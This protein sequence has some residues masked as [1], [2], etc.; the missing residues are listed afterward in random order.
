MLERERQRIREDERRR[1]QEEQVIRQ[2][3]RQEVIEDIKQP[4][5]DDV[6]TGAK[7]TAVYTASAT[8]EEMAEIETAFDSLGITWERKEI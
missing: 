1:V 5:S 2:E 3:A 6:V 4:I 7:V 8:P